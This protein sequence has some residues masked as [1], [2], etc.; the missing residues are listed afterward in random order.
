MRRVFHL[1]LLM[2]IVIGVRACGGVSE[3]EDALGAATGW[4]SEKTGLGHAKEVFDTTLRP[5][6]V[7]VTK[8]A[9]DGLYKAVS[10]ALEKGE[11]GAGGVVVWIAD[12][13]DDAASAIANAVP[14]NAAPNRGSQPAPRGADAQPPASAAAR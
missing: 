7:S 5:R 3:A 9:F 2:L 12:R 10:L 8:S 6:I 4:T 13:V 14:S 11:T 1:V